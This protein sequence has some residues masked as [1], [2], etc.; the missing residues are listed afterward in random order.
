ML[1]PLRALLPLVLICV[2]ACRPSPPPDARP[3]I[4][5]V[6]VDTLRADAVSAFGRIDGTTPTLDRLAAQG[7]LY[8]RA[9]APAPWTIPS[10]VSLFTG[11]GVHEHAVGGSAGVTAGDEL[12]MLAERLREAGYS[13]GGFVENRMVGASF[14]FAQGFE[15]FEEP[16]LADM[17]VEMEPYRELPFDTPARVA[18]WLSALPAGEPF[19]L[20]VNLFDPHDPYKRRQENRFV[21]DGTSAERLASVSLRPDAICSNVPSAADLEILRGLYHG[22]VSRADEKLRVIF[23]AATRAAEGAAEGAGEGAGL[24]TVVTS[25]HGELFGEDRLVEHSFSLHEKLLHVPLVL[26]GLASP[27][28][29]IDTPVSLLD[30]HGEILAR[31]GVTATWRSLPVPGAAPTR[32]L[33]SDLFAAFSDR[34]PDDFPAWFRDLPLTPPDHK[35]RHCGPADRVFGNMASLTRFPHKL[36]WYERYPPALFDLRAD[37]AQTVDLSTR[38]PELVAELKR[39]AESMIAAHGLFAREAQGPADPAAEESMRLLGYD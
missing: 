24:L 16:S 4:L 13:T 6:V 10:H 20:F 14:G 32:P 23:D 25:D 2:A 36:I 5:L 38:E 21:P 34:W 19:F 3:S 18:D 29:T 9:Y 35:R 28:A 17:M 26:H 8:T 31:A 27:P 30:V 15:K 33:R 12:V 22:D 39:S 1:F 37:P 7:R 11:L